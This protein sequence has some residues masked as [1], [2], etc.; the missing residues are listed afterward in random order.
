MAKGDRADGRVLQNRYELLSQLGS[1]GMGSVWL[2]KDRVLQREVALKELLQYGSSPDRDERRQRAFG[3]ARA[4]A[5]VK[6]P[7]I[8]RIHD[9]FLDQDDPW[10]VMD[11]ISGR[12]LD[13]IIA[14]NPLDERTAASVGL[15]VLR[16]L[17]A[18]HRENIVH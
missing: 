13:E 7:N 1:G 10:L 2:A 16:G 11:Y 8:V 15:P 6:H 4:M 5:K 3:E 18:A 17:E 9:V 12:S 14:N